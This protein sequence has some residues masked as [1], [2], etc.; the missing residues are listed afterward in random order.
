M[1]R[2]LK[3]PIE[4]FAKVLW[5]ADSETAH[6]FGKESEINSQTM[7][8]AVIKLMA[9]QKW[10]GINSRS[11]SRP[12]GY[13]ADKSGLEGFATAL[14]DY[15]T[16]SGFVDVVWLDTKNAKV[17][18]GDTYLT[19]SM[20]TFA[21]HVFSLTTTGK[22]TIK[23]TKA[24]SEYFVFNRMALAGKIMLVANNN[25]GT[26]PFHAILTH[27]NRTEVY[28]AVIRYLMTE[29]HFAYVCVKCD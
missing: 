5:E 19:V 26:K 24:D 9:G 29:N 25:S 20:Q 11:V 7:F 16:Q 23:R 14:K 27:D 2:F 21:G 10:F 3:L 18:A 28:R 4:E 13:F 12:F 15:L 22:F 8:G 6:A 1:E 17:P